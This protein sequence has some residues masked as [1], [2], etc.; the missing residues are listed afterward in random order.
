VRFATRPSHSTL[1]RHLELERSVPPP[2]DSYFLRAETFYNLST[3]IERKDDWNAYDLETFHDGAP[4][5]I[6]Y[7]ETEHY[8]VT[9][10]F[11]EY[12]DRMLRELT[13]DTPSQ[14]E[15]S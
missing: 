7:E 15:G 1:F 10:A 9:K 3:A 13:R 5:P 11:L 2:T 12:P 6:A 4:R 8:Q 14:E